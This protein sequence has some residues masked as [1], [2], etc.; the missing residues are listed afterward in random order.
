MAVALRTPEFVGVLRWQVG[1]FVIQ[2]RGERGPESTFVE[3][4]LL[5]RSEDGRRSVLGVE[6]REKRAYMTTNT[7]GAYA[8]VGYMMRGSRDR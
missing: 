4:P 2:E 7:E 5:F 8:D 1:A 6:T 3:Y